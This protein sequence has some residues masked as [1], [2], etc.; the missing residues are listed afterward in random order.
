MDFE[1]FSRLFQGVFEAFSSQNARLLDQVTVLRGT[2]TVSRVRNSEVGARSVVPLP[3]PQAQE[4]WGACYV[5][6]AFDD[7]FLQWLEALLRDS[8]ERLLHKEFIEN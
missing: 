8:V 3:L 6:N 2:S 5:D 7:L 1:A 4:P